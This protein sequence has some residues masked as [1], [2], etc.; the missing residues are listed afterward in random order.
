MP[1]T[2]PLPNI[3][4]RNASTELQEMELGLLG[5]LNQAHLAQHTADQSLDAQIRS[6]ETAFGMQREAPEAFDLSQEQRHCVCMDLNAGRR[7]AL[8]GNA[9][10]LAG[11]LN[12]E[13]GFW[14]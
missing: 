4:P 7:A 8:D 1:G 3:R 12:V 13:C 9:L 5:R 11:W 2:E 14:N 6:F 10:S